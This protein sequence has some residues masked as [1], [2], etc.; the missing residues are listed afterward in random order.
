MWNIY[1]HIH[2]YNWIILLYTRN[3]HNTVN[4]TYFSFFFFKKRMLP[5][6]S[7]AFGSCEVIHPFTLFIH[8]FINFNRYLLSTLYVPGLSRQLRWQRICLQYKRP[9]FDPWVGKIPWREW[10]PTPVFL[11]EASHGQ[12]SLVGYNPWGHK[13]RTR[14]NDWHFRFLCSR[15]GT[16]QSKE[17]L[18]RIFFCL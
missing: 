11:P 17:G 4:Q 2:I 15:S 14:L 1:I 13:S 5:K 7:H 12:K 8:K 9:R 10:Q 16:R 6:A 18:I 3:W